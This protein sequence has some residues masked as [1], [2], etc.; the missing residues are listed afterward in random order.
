M[1]Q[2]S[3]PVKPIKE[4]QASK[5]AARGRGRARGRATTRGRGKR[6]GK[7]GD[8]SKDEASA[9]SSDI[10]DAGQDNQSAAV[11]AQQSDRQLRQRSTDVSTSACASRGEGVLG[12][13]D[14]EID[15]GAAMP[16]L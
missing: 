12:G 11:P 14:D 7:S 13:D 8:V 9:S 5:G 3:K 4:G 6:R 15:W 2:S 16:D 10:S 1:G